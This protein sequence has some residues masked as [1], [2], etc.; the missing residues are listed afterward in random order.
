MRGKTAD[1]ARAE[2]LKAEV[3]SEQLQKILPH[4]VWRFSRVAAVDFCLMCC[5]AVWT[6]TEPPTCHVVFKHSLE[7][8][9]FR[10]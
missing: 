3:P 8:A 7:A 1:E 2:L 5:S 4:K 10:T 6:D 9:Q